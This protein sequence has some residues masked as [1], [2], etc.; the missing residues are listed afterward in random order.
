MVLLAQACCGFSVEARPRRSQTHATHASAY[1]YSRSAKALAR[2]LLRANNG[3][4]SSGLLRPAFDEWHGNNRLIVDAVNILLF[5]LS[6]NFQFERQLPAREGLIVQ[7]TDT[8]EFESVLRA[9]L[10]GALQKG[11]HVAIFVWQDSSDL[12]NTVYVHKTTKSI[13]N[14]LPVLACVATEGTA[15]CNRIFITTEAYKHQVLQELS[16]VASCNQRYWWFASS[17]PRRTT[18]TPHGGLSLERIC[19]LPVSR[20]IWQLSVC[21]FQ[22]DRISYPRVTTR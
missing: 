21:L 2:L 1:G 16:V 15:V 8:K 14:T 10:N 5:R 7:A 12:R 18:A 13:E 20:E 17:A 3:C 6:T 4:D 9:K 19:F 22:A 11:T